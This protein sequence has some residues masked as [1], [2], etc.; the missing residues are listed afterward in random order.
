GSMMLV[1]DYTDVSLS[2]NGGENETILAKYY[3]NASTDDWAHG[4][5]E[6]TQQMVITDGHPANQR[7]TLLTVMR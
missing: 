2:R 6:I 5:Q 1:K 7:R 3:I 4:I